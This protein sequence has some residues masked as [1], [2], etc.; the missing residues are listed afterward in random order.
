MASSVVVYI[1][2]YMFVPR[3]RS[4][5]QKSLRLSYYK[6]ERCKLQRHPPHVHR[7]R[8]VCCTCL[9]CSGYR[10]DFPL[11]LLILSG[12]PKPGE[13]V[14]VGCDQVRAGSQT[15]FL[16]LAPHG[17]HQTSNRARSDT[18]DRFLSARTNDVSYNLIDRSDPSTSFLRYR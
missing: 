15:K 4:A 10:Q 12:S 14:P 3:A 17:A 13:W 6:M 11:S 9:T 16:S 7:K 18:I 2:Y 8:F 1:T 5:R